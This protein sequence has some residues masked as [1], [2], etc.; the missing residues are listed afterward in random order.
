MWKRCARLRKETNG[1]FP[2]FQ[3]S[4]TKIRI[5]FDAVAKHDAVRPRPKLQKELTDV[6]TRFRR[7]PVALSGDIS[8]MF[9]QVGLQE[10]DRQYQQKTDYPVLRFTRKSSSRSRLAALWEAE[11]DV[12]TFQVKPPDVS[13]KPTNINVLCAIA[14]LF[15]PLQFLSPFAVRAKI[16]M[17]EIWTAGIE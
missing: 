9:L 10:K 3:L 14:T 1:S 12:F 5:V 16:L 6:L 17:Q 2:I 7:A 15:D 13:K 8:E 4:G 11:R